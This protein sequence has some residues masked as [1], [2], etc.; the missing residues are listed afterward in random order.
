M[1]SHPGLSS[2]FLTGR[3]KGLIPSRK[4]PR[5]NKA[6]RQPTGRAS[7]G[8]EDTAEREAMA[9]AFWQLFLQ[10]LAPTGDLLLALTSVFFLKSHIWLKVAGE[11]QKTHSRYF[12]LSVSVS[13]S[14]CLSVSLSFCLSVFLSLSLSLSVCLSVPLC[15]CF[16]VCLSVCV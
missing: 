15:L 13:L 5:A 12:C 7:D 3:M 4:L 14:F 6:R 1:A 10:T 11:L 2:V 8:M 16:S 9:Q